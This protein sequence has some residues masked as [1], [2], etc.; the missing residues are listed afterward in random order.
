MIV[1]NLQAEAKKVETQV[2][3]EMNGS[4]SPVT[5]SSGAITPTESPQPP[6]HNYR[7]PSGLSIPLPSPGS[8]RSSENSNTRDCET[9]HRAKP[10]V[11]IRT[12]PLHHD[13]DLSSKG[14]PARL[15]SID[16]G[17]KGKGRSGKRAKRSENFPP[18][19]HKSEEERRSSSVI[20]SSAGTEK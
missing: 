6:K 1:P 12:I 8:N 3:N 14:L 10:D 18:K 4:A 16:E 15:N 20:R 11:D 5:D 13:D 9:S 2:M 19:D 7:H 17:I